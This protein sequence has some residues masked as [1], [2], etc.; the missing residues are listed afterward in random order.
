MRTSFAEMGGATVARPAV[1]ALRRSRAARRAIAA[2]VLLLLGPWAP[3]GALDVPLGVPGLELRFDNTLRAN[4]G[5]R[6]DPIDA[7]LGASPAFTGGEYSVP[8]GG[9]TAG[10]LDLLS[11]LDLSHAGRYGARVSGALWGD[12]AYGD[13]T[14]SR[15]PTLVAA[16]VPGS[17]VGDEY[18]DYTLHRYRGPWGEVLDAFVFARVDAGDVPVTVKAGR[19]TLYWGEA[20]ML[21]GATHGVSYAQMP[22]DLQ[23][24]LAV[25]GTEAKELFRPIASVSAQA[26]LTPALSIAAQVFLEWR[27]YVYPEGGTFLGAGDFA[28]DGPD[29]IYRNIGGTDAFLLNG[30]AR[31]PDELGEF[32]VALRWRPGWL[33]GTVG[34]YYRRFTDKF[35]AVLLT[36]NPGG[37]GPLSPDIPSPFR[38]DQYYA[39][40]VDLVGM[41]LAKQVLGA[42]VGLEASFRH[43]TPL[44]AQTLGFAQA[45]APPLEAVLFP[46]GAPRI[47]GNSYQ[48]RGDTVHGV[49]NAI[50]VFSTPLF[51]TASWAVEVTY[52]RW[53]DVRENQDMFFAEGYGVCRE[54][55][56]LGANARTKQDGCATRDHVAV[57]AGFTPTWYRVFPGVDLLVPLAVSWT[58]RGNSPVTMGGNEGSGNYGAGIAADVRNRY[59]LELR[60]ADYFGSTQYVG[61]TPHANGQMALLESR[62]NVTFTA[63]ATF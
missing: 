61:T 42:S 58:I 22:L 7:K 51:S 43:D 33:D 21:G 12:L 15:S 13:G 34:L 8:H 49:L 50:G 30:G 24:G 41:S 36:A 5:L 35:A 63:K 39:E 1:R 37:E 18:S 23:K 62:G 40:E 20:L 4:V 48:A 9:L 44:V 25:P 31:E 53:L 14:V 60:Y 19:H 29:G 46:N 16:G 6:T 2:L 28:F 11:E 17:Y 57:G 3:A 47:V 45:P 55:V 10:R 32:G 54:D 26:Q 56:A 52:S 59:R 38:Y 27:P